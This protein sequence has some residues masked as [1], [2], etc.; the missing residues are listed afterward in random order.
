MLAASNGLTLPGWRDFE[1]AVAAALDG[2]AQESKY[3]FDVIISKPDMTFGI[4]C[5]MR[6]ELNKAIGA[7]DKEGR[8]TMELSNSARKFW[9]YLKTKG[10]DEANYRNYPEEVGTALI[11][12]VKSWHEAE[13]AL[14][15]GTINLDKSS[16]L[17]LSWNKKEL[18]QLHQFPLALPN[19]AALRWYFPTKKGKKG[20]EPANRLCGDDATGTLFEWYGTSGGQLKYYP[21]AKDALWASGIFQLEPLPSSEDIQYGIIAKTKAYYPLLWDT[22]DEKH[23]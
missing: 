22:M 19:P 12:L 20:E 4:S 8:I 1:R 6:R 2:K 3:V 23:S 10:I 15:G 11:E 9:V 7:G 13:S 14:R 21:L 16:Y 5:K 18:Y 17:T